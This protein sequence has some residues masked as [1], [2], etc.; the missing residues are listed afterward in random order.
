MWYQFLLQNL[1]FAINLFAAL[2]FFAVSWLYLDAWF[3]HRT[4]KVGLRVVGFIMLSLSFIVHAT[5][6]ES[7]LIPGSLVGT[8]LH[9]VFTFL[10]KTSGYLLIIASLLLDHFELS[11]GTTNSKPLQAS[12]SV[13]ALSLPY[14]ALAFFISILY[15]RRVMI[16]L[17]NHLRPLAISF[18]VL[19]LSEFVDF[20]AQLVSSKSPAIQQIF[21][22]FGPVWLIQHL[23]FAVS[24]VILCRW[25]FAYLFK[26]FETQLFMIFTSTILVIFL[27]ITVS[28]TGLLVNNLVQENL[29]EIE[30]NAKVL[31]YSIDSKKS[32]TLSDTQIVAQDPKI[33]E[34]LKQNDRTTIAAQL[35]QLILAKKESLLDVINASGQIIAKG[36]DRE[37][38][39]DSMSDDSLFQQGARGQTGSSVVVKESVVAPE[40]SIRSVSP[41]KSEGKVEGV[42]M[43]GSILDNA[44]LDGI[45]KATGL[46]SS[47][48]AQNKIAATTLVSSDGITRPIGILLDDK[49]VQDSVLK[50][51]VIFTGSVNL[52]NQPFYGSFIP[53]KDIDNNPVGM[54]FVG[55]PQVHILQTAGRSIEL[56][57]LLTI[58]LLL[59]SIVPS[60]LISR[61]I[62]SQAR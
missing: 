43:V 35:E 59:L 54:V 25:V 9:T 49:T 58:I 7:Y 10:F 52:L 13:L 27:I 62:G 4:L 8:D 11:P 30:T 51:G 23:V 61:H 36:E 46:E 55:R 3:G 41:I 18:F 22:P 6:V 39:G 57:F 38:F 56:T 53:L 33:N 1:H 29:R 45:K 21:A 24:L 60:Y 17:E 47:L 2:V 48:Y 15:I 50:K 32:E 31:S 5:Y 28:F 42:V 20:T 16:G 37:K 40:I 19:A 26:R 14:P 34:E 12:Q 44:F